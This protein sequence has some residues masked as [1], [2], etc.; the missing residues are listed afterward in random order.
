MTEMSGDTAKLL[1]AQ[2]QQKLANAAVK[3]AERFD[4]W[5][6]LHSL[7]EMQYGP[8]LDLFVNGLN[9]PD[10][11]WRWAHITN[12]GYHYSVKDLRPFLGKLQTLLLEDPDEDVQMA[13]ASILGRISTWPDGALLHALEQD[14]NM[15]V[16]ETAFEAL[17]AL[18]GVPLPDL[19]VLRYE[20]R[21]QD[22]DITVDALNEIAIQRG[23][24]NR[25]AGP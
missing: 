22:K 17:L 1:L 13:A 19:R 25:L 3:K 8:A 9:D 15:M 16:K 12:L 24:G 6:Q 5:D 7:A 2:I 11:A 10:S 21:L 14:P 23:K 20:L 18:L 4:L